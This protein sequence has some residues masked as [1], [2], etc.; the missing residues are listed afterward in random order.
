MFSAVPEIRPCSALHAVND[1]APN[2]A[3]KTKA[4]NRFKESPV[5][6]NWF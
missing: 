4:N 1:D 6:F 2:T 5:C 3:I